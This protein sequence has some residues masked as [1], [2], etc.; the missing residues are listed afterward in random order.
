MAAEAVG[1][2]VVP[3]PESAA[4]ARWRALLLHLW[5]IRRLQRLFG[6]LGNFL[7]CEVSAC[8]R[9]RLRAVYP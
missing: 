2:T 4:V 5:R 6:Q 8:V 3:V 9:D 7:R 1:W